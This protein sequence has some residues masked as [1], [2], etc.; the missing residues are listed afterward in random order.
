[1]SW[2]GYQATL[3]T[4]GGGWSPG[5]DFIFGLPRSVLGKQEAARVRWRFGSCARRVVVVDRAV[6]VGHGQATSLLIRSRSV[7]QSTSHRSGHVLSALNGK[8]GFLALPFCLPRSA[9]PSLT[10]VPFPLSRSRERVFVLFFCL[11]FICRRLLS[12]FFAVSVPKS[13]GGF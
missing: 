4:Q 12:S 11:F 7:G 13:R 1:M 5:G 3:S 9:H 10:D 2:C 6:V 8:R